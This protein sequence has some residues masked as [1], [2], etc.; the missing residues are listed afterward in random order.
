MDGILLSSSS[1]GAYDLARRSTG[2]VPC[3]LLGACAPEES[4]LR[5]NTVS[6]D[7]YAGGRM[8]A[9]YLHSQGHRDVAL[10]FI[11]VVDKLGVAIPDRLSILGFDGIEYTALP[12][13]RLTTFSQ[14]TPRLAQAAVRL[15]LELIDNGDQG[16]YTRKLITPILIQRAT[17]RAVEQAGRA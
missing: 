15:L 5:A 12:N 9:K 14:N 16:E 2:K 3:I 11:Q 8:A 13:I 7:N 10:G 4:P 6:V 17:C 1:D